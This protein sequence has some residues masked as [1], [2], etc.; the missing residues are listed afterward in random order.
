ME[1]FTHILNFI[2]KYD[3]AI[4]LSSVFFGVTALYT[5][6]ISKITRDTFDRDNRPDVVVY[7]ES[8][9]YNIQFLEFSLE[10]VGRG[11]ARN[12]RANIDISEEEISKHGIRI[13]SQFPDASPITVLPPNSKRSTFFGI[14]HEGCL[15]LKPTK[16]NVTYED[17][18]GKK[19]N[20]IFTLDASEFEGLSPP[21]IAENQ[22]ANSLKN[23]DDHIKLIKQTFQSNRIRV[24]TI[25]SKEAREEESKKFKK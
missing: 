23:I 24:E 16:V 15:S 17:M 5:R 1:D 4:L 22:I 11:H 10:N 7:L 12:V 9:K 14:S 19:Y 13:K 2:Q 3:L 18:K 8:G 20:E 21:H 6:R 25:S